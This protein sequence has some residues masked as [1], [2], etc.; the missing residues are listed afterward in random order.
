MDSRLIE[1]GNEG[2]VTVVGT[3]RRRRGCCTRE[4]VVDAVVMAN[5]VP[6]S[7]PDPVSGY[8]PVYT[9]DSLPVLHDIDEKLF[10]NLG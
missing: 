3:G 10:L 4:P 9:R 8:P 6:A 1:V 2:L 7:Y 5:V